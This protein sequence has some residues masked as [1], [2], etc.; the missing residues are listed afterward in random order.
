LLS[1]HGSVFGVNTHPITGSQVSV[2]QG[3]VSLQTWGVV[4]TQT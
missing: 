4:L 1:L 3:L 2:V